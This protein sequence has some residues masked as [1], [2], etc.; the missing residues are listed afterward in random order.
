MDQGAMALLIGD[1]NSRGIVRPPQ[2]QPSQN[3]QNY[4]IRATVH[5]NGSL[6]GKGADLTKGSRCPSL[7]NMFE[8]EGRR[9]NIFEGMFRRYHPSARI[10]SVKFSDLEN[11]ESDIE[12]NFDFVIPDYAR[13]RG[14]E[15][16]FQPSLLQQGLVRR[17]A[18]LSSRE[19]P[20][21]LSAPWKRQQSTEIKLPK[22]A[23]CLYIPAKLEMKSKF[24]VYR[25]ELKLKG[26]A[27]ELT[28]ELSLNALKIE[29]AEYQAFRTFCQKVDEKRIEQVR[30]RLPK[31]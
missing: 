26:N 19:L 4:R 18:P 31:F 2:V 9:L 3:L 13:K 25:Y 20:M 22:G 11:L 8:Q 6:K 7:R 1:G 28:D 17:Y 24:G 16:Q 21:E 30:I 12:I 23:Q 27:L 10:P 15:L 29:V 14:G 5:P